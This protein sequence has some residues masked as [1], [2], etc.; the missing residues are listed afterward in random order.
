MRRL[1]AVAV[2]VMMVSVSACAQRGG[3]RGGGGGFHGGGAPVGGSRGGFAAAGANHF[4][5]DARVPSYRPGSYGGGEG[6]AGMPYRRGGVA[7]A[8]PSF[9]ERGRGYGDHDGRRGG[10][11]DGLGYGVVGPLNYGWLDAGE[12]G[13]P[14][15]GGYADDGGYVD[16]G[17]YGGDA[18]NGPGDGS[19]IPAE[20]YVEQPGSQGEP[21]P[22][23]SEPV[24]NVPR[25]A[26]RL[27]DSDAV[28][29]VFKDGRPAEKI[30]NYALTR[31]TLYVTDGRHREIA[32]ADLDLA[33][34]EKAN[35]AAGVNFQLPQLGQ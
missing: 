1:I 30:H 13:Y 21:E 24:A 4:A 16:D 7:G 29:L 2:V 34:T 11:R 20:N 9:Y 3:A 23:G 32:V 26:P 8:R 31:T 14:D 33:A 28:T 5:G 19:G 12:I 6:T 15:D 22:E 27:Y 18:A 10:R 25:V 35:R 17:S